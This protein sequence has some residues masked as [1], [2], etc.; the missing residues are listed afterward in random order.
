MEI[1]D[2]QIL[3]RLIDGDKKCWNRFVVESASLIRAMVY[4]TMSAYTTVNPSEVD[5]AVQNVYFRLLKDDCRLLKSYDREKASLSTWLGLIS[6]SVTIDLIRKR[7]NHLSLDEDLASPQQHAIPTDGT[8]DLPKGLLSERQELILRMLFD[9]EM[10]PD[11]VADVLG[12]EIQTVRSAKHK[13]I[14]KL[15]RYYEATHKEK[16]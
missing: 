4:K 11:E 2:S 5:D 12:V 10:G 1:V 16:S 9:K 14:E 6:R 15:R 8:I 7:R 3:D 13:A